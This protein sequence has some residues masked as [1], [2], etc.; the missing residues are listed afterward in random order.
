MATSPDG[1][2]DRVACDVDC[3]CRATQPPASA[4]RFAWHDGCVRERMSLDRS[5]G[6]RRNRRFYI[7]TFILFAFAPGCGSDGS[8]KTAPPTQSS[9]VEVPFQIT[10]VYALEQKGDSDPIARARY[11]DVT[12]A[13]DVWGNA[14]TIALSAGDAAY[15]DGK[16]L[17]IET[18]TELLGTLRVDYSQTV[19]KDKPS[20]LFELRRPNETISA[21]IP[22]NEALALKVVEFPRGV[23]TIDW[24]P[25]KKGAK[26]SVLLIAKNGCTLFGKEAIADNVDDP[27]TTTW[28]A[29]S[30]RSSTKDCEFEIQVERRVRSAAHAR[31]KKGATE[32]PTTDVSFELVRTE[33]APVTLSKR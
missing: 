20:Y 1:E 4:S 3:A 17:D 25:P 30:S 6:S 19:P 9:T 28:S 14:G 26:V 10:T 24:G 22:G 11:Y 33:V 7:S 13:L 12:Q 32:L 2:V 27:G 23:V 29:E 31:W 5:F 21:T 16:K 15:A 8:G 18:R